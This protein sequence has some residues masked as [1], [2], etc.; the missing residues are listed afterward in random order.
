MPLKSKEAC[1]KR[2]CCIYIHNLK[3]LILAT[4]L[5]D[6]VQRDLKKDD[7]LVERVRYRRG[8]TNLRLIKYSRALYNNRTFSYF[9]PMVNRRG[10][11]MGK[12][13]FPS[14]NTRDRSLHRQCLSYYSAD[15]K[16]RKCRAKTVRPS[17]LS[18]RS[19]EKYLNDAETLVSSFLSPIKDLIFFGFAFLRFSKLK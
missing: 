2:K 5:I 19:C 1:S 8:I 14:S 17:I 13:L 12:V 7:F 11:V 15:T 4:D 10:T 6:L 16:Y 3:L 18:L 9:S